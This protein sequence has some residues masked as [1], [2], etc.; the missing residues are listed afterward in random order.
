[1]S[2]KCICRQ[3]K[4]PQ[5]STMKVCRSCEKVSGIKHRERLRQE[6]MLMLR[7]WFPRY[8]GFLGTNVRSM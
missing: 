7:G 1:M 5:S 6:A 4:K 3:C 8:S 2:V